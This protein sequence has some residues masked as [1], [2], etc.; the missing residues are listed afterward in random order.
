VTRST[1]VR[2]LGLD[3]HDGCSLL[4]RDVTVDYLDGAEDFVRLLISE[5]GDRGSLS[6]ELHHA[7]VTWPEQ[8]HLDRGRSNVL[9]ALDL[10][11]DAAVLEIGVG[12]GAITR[13]LGERTALVDAVEPVAARARAA[14][15]RTEDLPGVRVFVGMSDD[16]PDV[17]AYDLV[18]VVGVLEYVGRGSDEQ[19]PYVAFL[20][21]LRRRLLPGGVLCLAIENQLGVK[22]LAGAREDHTGRPWDGPEGYPSADVA[23]TFS[24]RSLESLVTAAGFTRP[25]VLG[26][27]PDY[28]I[29][30]LVV[31]PALA[32][33]HPELAVALP[34]F[35]SPDWGHEL[36]RTADESLMWSQFVRAGLAAETWNSFLVLASRDEPEHE[37]WPRDRL[38]VYFN[39]D[40]AARW[41][42][43]ATVVRTSSGA[44]IDRTTLVPQSPDDVAVRTYSEPVHTGATVVSA[45]L[46]EPWRTEDLLKRWRDLV[47]EHAE[48]DGSGLW[49]LVPHNALV[50]DEGLCAIDLEWEVAGST[51]QDV[52]HR[53]LLLT[54]DA[55]AS[56]GWSGAGSRTSVRDLAGWLGVLLGC[57]PSFVDEAVENE[58]RF[59]AV[60][61]CGTTHG[62]GLRREQDHMRAAW[63]RRLS[64]LVADGE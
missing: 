40:R 63:K 45:L 16:L 21:S 57:A 43:R 25:S 1:P 7:A 64:D 52:L 18:V 30:R 39:T 47:H 44:R 15:V 13:Y 49:D 51:P 26:C 29:T 48:T 12:C 50:T 54:A 56:A 55:L 20:D 22:Y 23:R 8:Y 46:A 27:F 35:P 58:A 10:P 37:L 14:A 33:E 42:S 4:R 17:P 41:C 3:L 59:Q 38:G 5:A 6:D 61:I 53:G 24:R 36:R 9:R 2:D 19:Q 31:D 32:D 11:R 60:R 34:R 62:A 28:K